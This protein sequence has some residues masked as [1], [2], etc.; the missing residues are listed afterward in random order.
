MM[1]G[2]Y[3]FFCGKQQ[4]RDF[5]FDRKEFRELKKKKR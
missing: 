5:L 3:C 2:S 4:V 1:E